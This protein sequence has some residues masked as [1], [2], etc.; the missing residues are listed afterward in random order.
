MHYW[1]H[2]HT[3][4]L[5]NNPSMSANKCKIDCISPL[6]SHDSNYHAS[7]ISLPSINH[8][9]ISNAAKERGPIY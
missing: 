5:N 8:G 4:I 9:P 7:G 1:H 2:H 3:T 6:Q